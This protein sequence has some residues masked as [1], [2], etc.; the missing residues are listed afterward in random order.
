MNLPPK[1]EELC[2]ELF[3]NCDLSVLGL[4][5]C[6]PLSSIRDGACR[7]NRNLRS[8]LIPGSVHEIEHWA[9]QDC[10]S[11]CEVD[12]ELPS[13]L[14]S[15]GLGCF[16]ECKSLTRFDIVGTVSNIAGGFVQG[17]GVGDICVDSAN[18]H[19]KV[20]DEFLVNVS[21][22]LI[23]CYFGNE[24]DVRIKSSIEILGV[25]CF[26]ECD[27]VR[28][29]TFD[30][31]SKLKVVEANACQN[32][33]SLERVEFGGRLPTLDFLSFADCPLLKEVLFQPPPDRLPIESTAFWGC[34]LLKPV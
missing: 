9:F 29:V 2:S 20:I 21:E 25:A 17:S 8:V 24:S 6:L 14:I 18:R 30:A 5:S 7:D 28:N 33:K 34:P 10:V 32:C 31:G 11:L 22:T 4:D 26:A 16:S 19:F 13:S 12:F 15:I 27:F 23:V 1:L 3:R